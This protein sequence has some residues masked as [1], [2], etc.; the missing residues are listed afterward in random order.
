MVAACKRSATSAL[1]RAIELNAVAVDNNK[2]A[3][4]LGRLAAGD[5]EAIE[6]LLAGEDVDEAPRL[7]SMDALI[8]RGVVHLTG[9]QGAAYAKQYEDF[10][11]ETMRREQFA[12]ADASLPF[13]RAVA[14]G[15][16]KLMAYKDEYEVARLY[17][18]G[19]FLKSLKHQ[20]EGDVQLE[21]YMAPPV[22]SKLKNGQAPR[23]VRLGGWMMPA[24]KLLAQG[25][26]LRGTALDLFGRTQERRME[27]E[28]IAQYR[29]RIASMASVL[30]PDKMKVA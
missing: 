18:D 25:K 30:T 8:A 2:L 26:R 10:V 20:F 16:L 22:L 23:K 7:E 5:P 14:Q 28:L 6:S 15:L 19:D 27:R 17:T 12:T 9:Y 13:T 24:M 21:F 1:M 29:E 4:S 3:F 11:R